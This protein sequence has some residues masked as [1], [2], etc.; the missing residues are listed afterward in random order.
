MALSNLSKTYMIQGT[1]G[2]VEAKRPSDEVLTQ[3]R[4]L[5]H[6]ER[7]GRATILAEAGFTGSLNLWLPVEG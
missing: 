5:D 4:A 2:P 7:F 3:L 6:F 1:D